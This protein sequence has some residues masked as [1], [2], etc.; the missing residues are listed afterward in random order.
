[1]GCPSAKIPTGVVRCAVIVLAGACLLPLAAC[2]KTSDG[3]VILPKPPAVSSLVPVS[4]F[5][6]SWA[7]RSKPETSETII[8][9]SRF[10]PVPESTPAP[11]KQRIKPVVIRRDPSGKLACANQTGANGRVRVVCK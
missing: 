5:V 4:S 11:A 6:P 3:T 9:E 8:A 10:P 2:S 7:R 1:M